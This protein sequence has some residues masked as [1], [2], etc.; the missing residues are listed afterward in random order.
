MQKL[1]SFELVDEEATFD[2]FVTG[3]SADP[4]SAS[5]QARDRM[6]AILDRIETADGSYRHLL[7]RF[8]FSQL[9]LGSE[10]KW[11]RDID[12]RCAALKCKVAVLTLPGDRLAA[13]SL[14]RAEYDGADWQDLV[15]RHGS[16]EEALDTLRQ[17][18]SAR[19]GAIQQS[20][21]PY[22]MVDASAKAWERYASDIADWIGWGV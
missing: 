13:R 7:E 1:A 4:D 5:G 12:A 22:R 14:Y 2:D 11:Y 6:A 20:R 21:L 17:A 8:H 19:I 15:L 18:Q 16:E 10:W 9:A 3:F